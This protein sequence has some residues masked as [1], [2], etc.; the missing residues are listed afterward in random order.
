MIDISLIKVSIYFLIIKLKKMKK[1]IIK[2]YLIAI[3]SMVT[4]NIFAQDQMTTEPNF[5]FSI[6][7]DMTDKKDIEK[8]LL[9]YIEAGDK[10]DVKSLEK[11]THEN[12][13]VV[14]NDTKETAIKVLDRTTYHDLIG[15]KVFGGTHRDVEIQMIDVFG[16]TNATV[17]AQLTSEKAVFYNYYSLLKVL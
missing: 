2:L 13:R 11:V 1:Q 12:F 15:K 6:E 3:V 16:N 7:K 5:K 4:A 8:T 9:K 14:L 10:N 17:K